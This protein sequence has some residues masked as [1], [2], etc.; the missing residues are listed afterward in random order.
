MRQAVEAQVLSP[1]C[2][3]GEQGLRQILTDVVEEVRRTLNQDI[4]GTEILHSLLNAPWLQS[5][6]K[7]YECLQRYLRESPAPVLDYTS[8]LSFQLLIDIKAFPGCSEEAKELDR[9]LRQPHLQ[10]LLSAHDTVA[11]KN[12]EPVLP[13]MSD[14]VPDEEEATRIVCLVKNKQPLLCNRLRTCS[15]LPATSPPMAKNTRAA[16][17]SHSDALRLHL[18]GLL[19]SSHISSPDEN[20]SAVCSVR[21]GS[22]PSA[23]AASHQTVPPRHPPCDMAMKRNCKPL[24]QCRLC[25]TN[26]LWEPNVNHS[27]PSLYSSAVLIDDFIEELDGR[28]EDQTSPVPIHAP[29]APHRWAVSPPC[30]SLP[31]YA[32]LDHYRQSNLPPR[33]R[34]QSPRVRTAP[35]SPACPH[36]LVKIPRAPHVELAK[37]ESLDEL[38]STVQLAASS[39]ESST[40]D[41]QLLGERMAI[42]TERMSETVH[43]NSQALT[44]LDQVVDRLQSVLNTG[45]TERNPPLAKCAAAE[46]R[47]IPINSRAQRPSL[48]SMPS[49]ISSSCSSLSSCPDVPSTS[50]ARSCLSGSCRGSPRDKS[51]YPPLMH[52]L[53]NGTLGEAKKSSSAVRGGRS[54]QQKK[55]KKT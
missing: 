2:E 49:L 21:R 14:D 4:D 44:L 33:L 42:A 23:E 13:P 38:R 47:R 24:S 7:V 22:Y 6:L 26:L 53:T 45:R 1:Y 52:H 11:Q 28:N 40:K 25:Y 51:K 20:A 55:G 30:L 9:L 54:N 19:R 18:E 46:Q 43:D 5:L 8:D 34:N 12:Y 17:C 37:Q 41:I 32:N 31:Y 50:R 16:I 10:A 48:S 39:M 3:L 15:Q 35:P 36:R 27:S 29:I